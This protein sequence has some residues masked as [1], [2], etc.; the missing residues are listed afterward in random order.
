MSALGFKSIVGSLICAWWRHMCYTSLRFTSGV[1]PTDLLAASM[2]SKLISSTYLWAGIGGA[3]NWDLSCRKWTLYRLYSYEKIEPISGELGRQNY[4]LIPWSRLNNLRSKKSKES[5]FLVFPKSKEACLKLLMRLSVW[6]DGFSKNDRNNLLH[7]EM[8]TQG[9]TQKIITY[10]DAALRISSDKCVASEEH[11]CHL[12][13]QLEMRSRLIVCQRTS[14]DHCSYLRYWQ[15][16]TWCNGG[17]GGGGIS[18][19]WGWGTRS[20]QW[21]RKR[22]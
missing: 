22:L 12:D 3:W 18:E 9:F 8:N 15:Y 7:L 1:T 10:C 5:Y 11:H 2:A 6:I 17:L 13:Y 21:R 19:E 14:R 4:T 20:F 16:I